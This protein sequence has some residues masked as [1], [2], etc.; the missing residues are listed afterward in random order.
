MG[1]LREMVLALDATDKALDRKPDPQPALREATTDLAGV[2]AEAGA[3]VQ[4]CYECAGHPY[5]RETGEE[6]DACNG[7]GW[8]Q[9]SGM[10]RAH[11]RLWRRAPDA[12]RGVIGGRPAIVFLNEEAAVEVAYLDA[13]SMEE[14]RRVARAVGVE[15]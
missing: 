9:V 14:M 1:T 15:P 5:N 7:C 13:L 2:P 10:W 12:N 4:V 3:L 6:C 11:S 8:L